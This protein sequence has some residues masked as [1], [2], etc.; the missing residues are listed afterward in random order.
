M[1]IDTEMKVTG[2]SRHRNTFNQ[3]QK[4]KVAWAA[5]W[6]DPR[7]RKENTPLLNLHP[8]VGPGKRIQNR[9]DGQEANLER[10]VLITVFFFFN[11]METFQYEVILEKFK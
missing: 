10:R 5:A 1:P 7:G 4:E 9:A 8:R 11:Q 3:Q 6:M 2:P